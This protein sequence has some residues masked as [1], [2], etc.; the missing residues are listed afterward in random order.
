MECA[1]IV[2]LAERLT[3]RLRREDP[4]AGRVA[5]RRT[6]ALHAAAAALKAWR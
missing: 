6:D 1:A 5:L 4:L 3:L 2:T